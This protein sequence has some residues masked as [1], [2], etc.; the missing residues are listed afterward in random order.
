ME[1]GACTKRNVYMRV[2]VAVVVGGGG[3]GG[4]GGDGDNFL[5]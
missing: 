2:V 3:G 4:G 1:T 5:S